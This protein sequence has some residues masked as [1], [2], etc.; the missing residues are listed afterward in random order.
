MIQI[1]EHVLTHI[2]ENTWMFYIFVFYSERHAKQLKHKNS[3]EILIIRLI[4][5]QQ[6]D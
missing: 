4:Y 5:Y 3:R 1:D 6:G 2:K